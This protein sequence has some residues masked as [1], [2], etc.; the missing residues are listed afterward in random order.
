MSAATTARPQ[1]GHA[2]PAFA[3]NPAP[4]PISRMIM[5]Q[6]RLET[7]LLLRNAEQLL[8]AIV[9]PALMLIVFA[10]EPIGTVVGPSRIDYYAPGIIGAAVL[11]TAFTSQAIATGFERRYGVLKR[12]GATPLPRW[13]L[14]AGK[15]LSVLAVECVQLLLLI[16]IAL[17]MGWHPH[18]SPVAVLLLLALGTAAF[19]G[20]A[21][22][23]AGSLRA[24]AT[25]A[26]ANFVFLVFLAAGGVIVPLEKFGS[27]ARDVL[28]FLPISALTD[29]L[30]AVL[31]NGVALPWG[32]IGILAAWAVV[33]I[34]AAARTFKWE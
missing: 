24:E 13:G 16:V 11:S 17:L 8:L 29:G 6:A 30:R 7:T 9:I 3:P 18:G 34:A 31:Q 1:E 4:A 20:L 12:L 26:L 23:L 19:S 2:A 22:L 15:A 14:L 33:A 21:L 32:P 28:R 25:L 5:A 27:G 10:A